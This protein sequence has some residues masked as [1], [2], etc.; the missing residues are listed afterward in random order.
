MNL[1]GDRLVQ[2]TLEG[3]SPMPRNPP[4][5]LFDDDD[6]NAAAYIAGIVSLF[7]PSDRKCR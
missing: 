7:I 3:N 6:I 4:T 2:E 1:E 5:E